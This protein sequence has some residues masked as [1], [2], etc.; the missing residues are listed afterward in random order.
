VVSFVPK[1]SPFLDTS[2]LRT[3][4]LVLFGFLV[5]LIALG[6][7][8]IA[9]A[10]HALQGARENLV[11]R[12]EALERT[13]NALLA[14]ENIASIGRL[15]AEVSEEI[16]TPI[17]A[18]VADV[19][20]AK[21]EIAALLA[22]DSASEDTPKNRLEAVSRH[23]SRIVGELRRAAILLQSLKRSSRDKASGQLRK[24]S[25]AELLQDVILTLQNRLHRERAE[26]QIECPEGLWVE[27]A[28]GPLNLVLTHLVLYSLRMG[29]GPVS[30]LRLIRISVSLESDGYLEI[31]YADT[32][33][34]LSADA[35]GGKPF[36]FPDD[37]ASGMELYLCHRIVTGPLAGRIDCEDNPDGGLRCTISCPVSKADEGD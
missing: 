31:L 8:W 5:L 27:G 30:H 36:D 28:P 29:F 15:V 18:A 24:F 20:E 32:S 16:D 23:G 10:R 11:A 2:V 34:G 3:S 33:R 21:K 22:D 7:W 14:S 25:V 37:P 19:N 1:G 17:R 12:D 26:I 6:S 9:T 35:N 13:R 4:L